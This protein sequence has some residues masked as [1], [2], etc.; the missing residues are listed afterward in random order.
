MLNI[1]KLFTKL[2]TT[3][4]VTPTR[5]GSAWTSGDIKAY[6]VGGTV[7]LK[8]SGAHINAI[9]QRTTIATLPEGYRPPAEVT[10]KPDGTIYIIVGTGGAIQ[11]DP[12][13]GGTFYSNVTFVAKLGGGN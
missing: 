9:T 12:M 13:N 6:R 11:I 1:K 8:F 3:E 10:G 7:F 2:M 4:S 5:V